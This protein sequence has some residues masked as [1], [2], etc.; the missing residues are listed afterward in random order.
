MCVFDVKIQIVNVLRSLEN[1]IFKMT[2]LRWPATFWLHHQ[3]LLH[4]FKP[5]WELGLI[6][7]S[8][9]CIPERVNYLFENGLGHFCQWAKI[10]L[11]NFSH[12]FRK[13]QKRPET[14]FWMNEFSLCTLFKK[15]NICPKIQFWQYPNIFTSFSTNIFLTIFL[16]KSKLSTAKKSKTTTFSRVFLPKKSTIFSGNQSWIFG[17]EMKISNSV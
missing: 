17:Q 6:C 8:S 14:I 2:N 12:L 9:Y 4:Q 3:P 13:H 5:V 16:V 10:K 15:S 7:P 11:V 1:V